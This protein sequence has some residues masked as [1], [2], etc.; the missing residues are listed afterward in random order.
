MWSSEDW[1][2]KLDSYDSW[3]NSLHWLALQ[4]SDYPFGKLRW[5]AGI[6][7]FGKTKPIA[8]YNSLTST[9]KHIPVYA[10]E[11]MYLAESSCSVQHIL[12][13][14]Y[15]LVN[16]V[17]GS[18]SNVLPSGRKCNI[19]TAPKFS[20]TKAI[21]ATSQST[22]LTHGRGSWRRPGW[23]LYRLDVLMEGKHGIA[24]RAWPALR[25]SRPQPLQHCF[26]RPSCL[27][28]LSDQTASSGVWAQIMASPLP[29]WHLTC[30]SL[31]FLPYWKSINNGSILSQKAVKKINWD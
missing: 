6:P 9:T 18:S 17:N 19:S 23:E 21:L 31:A 12:E 24:P 8:W 26:C 3:R 1:H 2:H 25:F 30:L 27:A 14:A 4:S 22:P 13:E 28:K 29:L 11:H 16:L 10:C 20:V 15:F 7:G 5:S